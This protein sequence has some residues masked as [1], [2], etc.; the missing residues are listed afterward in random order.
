MVFTSIRDSLSAAA[1]TWAFSVSACCL[2]QDHP[3]YIPCGQRRPLRPE[4]AAPLDVWL[5]SQ[6]ARCAAGRRCW[7]LCGDVAVLP[8]CTVSRVSS[9][10]LSP[11]DLFGLDELLAGPPGRHCTAVNCNPNCNPAMSVDAGTEDTGPYGPPPV[12]WYRCPSAVRAACRAAGVC[13]VCSRARR[14]S[15][16]RLTHRASLAF[17]MLTF[18]C[19]MEESWRARLAASLLR[20]RI[21][22]CDA[23]Q[24]MRA[25]TVQVLS[26]C[27]HCQLRKLNDATSVPARPAAGGPRA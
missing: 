10:G 25:G 2:I 17:T 4:L 19:F 1:P 6:L 11:P 18:S 24:R 14:R 20:L 3:A 23:R 7:L 26:V 27:P 5:S 9:L 13:R 8:C 12:E 16:H 21:P 22:A 15:R